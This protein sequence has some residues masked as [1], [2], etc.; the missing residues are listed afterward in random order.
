VN[1]L[2]RD[3]SGGLWVIDTGSPEFGGDPLPA[4]AKAV[5]IDLKSGRVARTVTFGP[6]AIES[7][8]TSAFMA[9]MPI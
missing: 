8:T 9:T 3:D 4:A 2:H 5:R 6:T 1:S 7:A